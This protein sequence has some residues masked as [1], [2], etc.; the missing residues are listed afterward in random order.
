MCNGI[1]VTASDIGIYAPGNPVAYA[2]PACPEH[3]D[4]SYCAH[5]EGWGNFA[6]R[7]SESARLM[8][9]MCGGTGVVTLVVS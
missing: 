3:G 1:C 2:H 9:P 6:G 7:E 8:C 4:E 5:C